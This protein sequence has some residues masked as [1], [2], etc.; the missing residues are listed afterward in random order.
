MTE[1]KT[2]KNITK[3]KKYK[4][5]TMTEHK[6]DMNIT[7]YKKKLNS[8]STVEYKTDMSITKYKTT[9]QHFCCRIQNYHEHYWKTGQHFYEGTLN[10]TQLHFGEWNN[11]HMRMFV[12]CFDKFEWFYDCN[13]GF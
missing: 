2:D 1:H 4:K 12:K 9:E 5:L 13:K 8:N 3:I 11:K 10:R 6:A 7:K